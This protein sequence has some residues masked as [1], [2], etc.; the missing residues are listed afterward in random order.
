M[1]ENLAPFIL[2]FAAIDIGSNAVRLLIGYF[3]KG[4]GGLIFK[5]VNRTRIPLRLGEDV[6]LQG[7]ISEEKIKKLIRAIT[8]FR[9]L[10]KNYEVVNYKACATSALREASN[11]TELIKRIACE[12]GIAI[13]IIDGKTEARIIYSNYVAENLNSKKNYLFIDVGGG[14]T[15]LT[16]VSK[17][18]VV[19]SRSFNVGTLRLLHGLVSKELKK[20]FKDWIKKETREFQP[21]VAIGSGGNIR[22]LFK[23]LGSRRNKPISYKKLT[24]L[25]DFIDSFSLE[26]RIDLLRM[27]PD[28]ADVIVPA[29]KIF[30]IIMKDGNVK[31]IYVPAIGLAEG[32]I[33]LLYENHLSK[34]KNALVFSK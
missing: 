33:R 10:L 27:K 4:K 11:A 29:A 14:S 7:N 21:L 2:N 18:K 8:I 17:N 16:L 30:L 24:N 9:Q 26:D 34:N 15:E 1:Y 23:L 28:R 31:Q 12:T 6:F 5:K 20:E 25:K 22:K 32:L 19:K 3:Y 13:E